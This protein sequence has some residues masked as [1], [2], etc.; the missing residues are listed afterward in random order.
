MKKNI[1][2][3]QKQSFLLI[4]LKINLQ[5]YSKHKL[6]FYNLDNRCPTQYYACKLTRYCLLKNSNF[7]AFVLRTSCAKKKKGRSKKR[8]IYGTQKKS[9]IVVIA[10]NKNDTE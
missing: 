3:Q 1:N 7:M 6:T 4:T 2:G 8:S 5:M 9:V 10:E